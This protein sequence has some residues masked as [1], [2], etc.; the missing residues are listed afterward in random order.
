MG[1]IE[2]EIEGGRERRKKG[3]RCKVNAPD[4]FG[5]MSHYQDKILASEEL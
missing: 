2:G 3:G 5:M 1:R 4:H